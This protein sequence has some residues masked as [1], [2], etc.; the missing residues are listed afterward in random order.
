L[1]FSKSFDTDAMAREAPGRHW[2]SLRSSQQK[3]FVALFRELL[4]RTYVQ[5]L[6]LFQNRDFVYAGQQFTQDGSIMDTKIVTPRDQFDVTHIGSCGGQPACGCY[7]VED[8]NLIAAWQSARSCP[9]S[10]D[11]R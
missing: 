10:N 5:T 8:V 11:G 1:L 9:G 7:P 6:L 4:Q 3:E 2:S